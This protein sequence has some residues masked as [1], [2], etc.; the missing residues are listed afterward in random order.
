MPSA[1]K[2]QKDAASP[3]RKGDFDAVRN[4][5]ASILDQPDYDDGSIGPVLV[6]L[7]W[8]ASGTYC[9][10]TK[11]GGS[12]GAGMRYEAE[13]GDP[14]NAGLEHARR[15]L[16]PIKEKHPWITYADLWTL[17][18]VVAIKEMGGP[19]CKWKPGRTDFVDESKCPPRGRLPDGAQAAE[20]LRFI[21][22]R[23]GFNDQEIVALAGAHSLGRCHSDRSGFEGPWSVTPTKF[24][25]QYYKMLTKFKW[26]EKKWEGPRQFRNE[27]LGEE[28]MM[29]PTDMALI[30]DEKFIPWVQ[31]YAEDREAFY[32]DFADVFSKLIELGVERTDDYESAPT[33]SKAEGDKKE[34]E[35]KS[36]I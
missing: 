23:M 31:K 5:I 32:K 28:L 2:T 12:N 22:Y 3:S 14:A 21:F 30:E 20:H 36:K 11:T 34:Q 6:R 9:D 15:F 27:D 26:E 8:H 1:P 25:T 13:G 4:D 16:E 10:K 18:G 24:S 7:A 17:A 29:L 33:F 19:D 35:A